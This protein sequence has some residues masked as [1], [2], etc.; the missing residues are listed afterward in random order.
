MNYL[1]ASEYVAYGLDATTPPAVVAA[2]SSLID[3]HWPPRD[4]GH[5][6]IRGAATN[7]AGPQHDTT[8]LL[9]VGRSAAG[10][11]ANCFRARTIFSSA[12]RRAAIRRFANGYRSYIRV[13][14]DVECDRSGLH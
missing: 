13:T 12:T 8:D 5:S 2:A 6:A 11:H 10:D 7:F 4:V 14:G 3:S 9:P 1:S